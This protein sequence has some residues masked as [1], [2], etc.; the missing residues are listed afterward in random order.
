MNW[1]I[2]SHISFDSANRVSKVAIRLGSRSRLTDEDIKD[3]LA[4]LALVEMLPLPLF[5]FHRARSRFKE[6]AVFHMSWN[7]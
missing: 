4:D 3:A 2:V 1:R 7:D 6:S 5:Q